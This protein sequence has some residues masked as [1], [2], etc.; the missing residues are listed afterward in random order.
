MSLW[1]FLETH[2]TITKRARATRGRV[3]KIWKT[4]FVER[5]LENPFS[6]AAEKGPL[7]LSPDRKPSRGDPGRHQ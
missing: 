1:R 2:T 4:C 7:R 6:K 5:L 3:S